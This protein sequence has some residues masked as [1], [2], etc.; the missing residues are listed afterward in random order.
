KKSQVH[1]ESLDARKWHMSCAG[2]ALHGASA[3]AAMRRM[4]RCTG[5]LMKYTHRRR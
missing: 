4:T 5:G 2:Q 3:G 1:N